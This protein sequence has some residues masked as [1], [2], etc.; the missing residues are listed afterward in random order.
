MKEKIKTIP[1]FVCV[2]LSSYVGLQEIGWPGLIL[3]PILV[4]AFGIAVSYAKYKLS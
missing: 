4:T 2:A 3:G 1:Y